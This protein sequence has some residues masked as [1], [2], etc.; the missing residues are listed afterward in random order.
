MGVQCSQLFCTMAQW[1]FLSNIAEEL[2]HWVGRAFFTVASS[3]VFS[4]VCAGTVDMRSSNVTLFLKGILLV[5][6]NIPL[7]ASVAIFGGYLI[8]KGRF[9]F[10]VDVGITVACVLMV[11]DEVFNGGW[12]WMFVLLTDAL[13]TVCARSI[14]L[15]LQQGP[16]LLVCCCSSCDVSALGNVVRVTL[17]RYGVLRSITAKYN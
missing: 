10:N 13:G 14:L 12:V 3:L 15:L 16:I 2:T 1:V 17:G 9:N 6:F 7:L 11:S 8:F 5:D 4:V